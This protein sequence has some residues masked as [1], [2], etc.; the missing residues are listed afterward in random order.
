MPDEADVER[1]AKQKYTEA[2]RGR[3]FAW[4]AQPEP[5]KRMWRNHA[6]ELL[7]AQRVVDSNQHG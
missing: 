2:I 7:R 4:D 3:G 5:T 1:L 6:R